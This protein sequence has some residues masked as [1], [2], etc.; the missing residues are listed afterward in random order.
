[1]LRS[2]PMDH[3]MLYFG[4]KGI[5]ETV[6]KIGDLSIL[7]IEDLNGKIKA[8]DKKHAKELADIERTEQRLAYI[9]KDIKDIIEA[10]NQEKKEYAL[11]KDEIDEMYNRLVKLKHRQQ[12]CEKATV[13]VEEQ[14]QMLSQIELFK[15]QVGE[16][17]YENLTFNFV[18]GI[19]SRSKKFIFK[20][21]VHM[22]LRNN[23]FVNMIDVETNNGSA[24]KT[25][26]IVYAMGQE[27]IKIVHSILQ[28]MD[29]RLYSDK[30][31]LSAAYLENKE[32]SIDFNSD[33]STKIEHSSPNLYSQNKY[34]ATEIHRISSANLST[35][36]L[37]R[38]SS[39]SLPLLN[40]KPYKK[41]NYCALVELYHSYK[42]QLAQNKKVEAQ[43][44]EV[45]ETCCHKYSEWLQSLTI[46]RRIYETLNKLDASS[47]TEHTLGY[48]WIARRDMPILDALKSFGS[49][50]GKFLFEK[51]SV[52][53]VPPTYFRTNDFTQAFQAFTN[54][55]GLPKYQEL[56]PGIFMIFTFPFL[57]GA[58]FGDILHGIFLICIAVFMIKRYERLNNNCG[59]FQIILDGRYVVFTC[60]LAAIWFGL[61]YGDFG[62]LPVTLFESQFKSGRAY[63]FGIDPAWHHAEN[64][65]TFING[66]KMKLS[67][68]I[69]FAHMGLGAVLS[70]LNALHFKDAVTFI[71]VSLPQ[72]IAFTLFLG[73]LV[74]LCIFK[75]LVT[76]NY[77][78]LVN[79]LIGMYTDP[80]NIRQPMYG[81]QLYVQLSI[82]AA[83]CLCIPWMFVSKPLYLMAKKRVPAEGLLDLW[84]TSG[85][86]VVEF[87]LGLISNTSSYLRLWAVSLAHVQLTSVLHQFTIGNASLVVSILTFPIYII[88]TAL[89][90]IGLEGLSACLHALRLNWIEFFSKFYS[91]SGVPYE[92]LTFKLTHAELHGE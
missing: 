9:K 44:A 5:R 61:L 12:D 7:Q 18:T 26:V 86:H 42:A 90:L 57:F 65:M 89:L 38:C 80:L 29:G 62:S 79:T 10:V 39:S 6:E 66:V 68:I 60:G 36:S 35:E 47:S 83:I 81:G 1:M 54:V 73:Y 51:V 25:V 20:D 2:E 31:D 58:M 56:N 48:A 49:E 8:D 23:T 92:P 27:A 74:F 41:R 46:E 50:Q 17:C 59:V 70:L 33:F 45:T 77:P 11:V 87:A 72:F 75:W 40:Q 67:I 13:I 43:I 28:S 4:N 84:I 69:G 88:T 21:L 34:S 85:I 64:K 15:K 76:K 52:A 82:F 63:P 24:Q 19:L 71:C 30:T 22:R 14:Y 16:S 55:F 37:G 53:A 91:G 32:A 78:S 3:L